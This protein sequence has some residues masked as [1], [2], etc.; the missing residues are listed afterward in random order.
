MTETYAAQRWTRRKGLTEIVP[1]SAFTR[2]PVCAMSICH[3]RHSSAEMRDV[4][5]A[6]GI[7]PPASLNY[8]APNLL[9]VAPGGIDKG[10]GVRRALGILEVDPTEAIAFG[11]MPNDLAMFEACGHSVAMGD[12]EPDVR[13][14]ATMITDSAA[15]DGFAKMLT[16][17]GIIGR[18]SAGKVG[19]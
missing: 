11:D 7:D 6:A 5:A 3:L 12:A 8:G 1:V 19:R 18:S 4:L 15:G 14:A 9:D 2:Q 13:A 17:L 16:K 10:T